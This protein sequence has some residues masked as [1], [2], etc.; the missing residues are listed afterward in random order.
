[1]SRAMTELS[2]FLRERKGRISHEDANKLGLKRIKKIDFSGNIHLDSVTDTKTDMILVKGGDLVISGINA[3]KGAIAVYSEDE[4][5]LATI[6]YS[7]YEFDS[8][9]ISIEFLI[10]FFK[11][12]EFINLLKT[13]VSGGIKTELKPKDILPLKIRLPSLSEQINIAKSLNGFQNNYL[14]VQSEISYQMTLIKKLR[15]AILD[16]AF[17]GE[18]TTDWRLTQ[19]DEEQSVSLLEQIEV[20]RADANLKKKQ[21]EKSELFM[22]SPEE[23]PF[24]IP[25]NWAWCR[26]GQIVSFSS[27]DGLT[28]AQMAGGE[29]PV[30]G[31]NGINGFHNK[32]N[33]DSEQ[34]VVGRVGAN[35]GAV[36]KTPKRAWVTDNAFITTYSNSCLNTD[37]LFYLLKFL[38]LNQLSYDGSQPVISGKRVYPLPTPL[39][40]L[41][42]Q[43]EIAR[44]VSALM[45]MCDSI[46]IQIQDSGEI[47]KG[48]Y[49]SALQ[50][51][52]L[53]VG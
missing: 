2:S 44:K 46:E 19:A 9:S 16:E 34:I 15:K 6:H 27:G 39:P 29:I 5:A 30:F 51:A 10:W 31:G 50:E 28:S 40:P 38:N 13:Q 49:Q 52:F 48:L 7:S 33:I 32:A 4:E 25:K 42:E 26:L 24:P 14:R 23:M 45:L 17:K 37:F 8:D 18:L 47:S 36:H 35:C 22:V 43:V 12:P 11:S 53:V 21:R 41:L 1:M 20:E 3:S